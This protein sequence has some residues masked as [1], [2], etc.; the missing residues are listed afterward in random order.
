MREVSGF[1]RDTFGEFASE[2]VAYHQWATGGEGGEGEFPFVYRERQL[3]TVL[4]PALR[5]SSDML[6][7]EQPFVRGRGEEKAQGWVD[8]WVSCGSTAYFLEIKHGWMNATTAD[9]QNRQR[10]SWRNLLRQTRK[11]TAEKAKDISPGHSRVFRIAMLFM[12]VY[13]GSES[14]QDLEPFSRLA[15][16]PKFELM[17]DKRGTKPNWS[18]AWFLHPKLQ[19]PFESESNFEM[20]PAVFMFCLVD[21]LK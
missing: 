10:N 18:A 4:L 1:L 19:G 15:M 2:S 20:Y 21:R 12:P 7:V 8:F 13:S 14:K 16:K 11:I 9:L 5:S 3:T 6:F 17:T